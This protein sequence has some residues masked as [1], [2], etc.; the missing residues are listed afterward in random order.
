M[1]NNVNKNKDKKMNNYPNTMKKPIPIS[2]ITGRDSIFIKTKPNKLTYNYINNGNQIKNNKILIN[3]INQSSE[4]NKALKN[5]FSLHKSNYTK[6]I[7]GS[8]I[9]SKNLNNS[10]LNELI[11]IKKLSNN[12]I[13]KNIHYRGTNSFIKMNRRNNNSNINSYINNSSNHILSFYIFMNKKNNNSSVKGKN[14]F[15]HKLDKKELINRNINHKINNFN[16]TYIIKRKTSLINENRTN[17]KGKRV[18]T[19]IN[20]NSYPTKYNY[21]NNLS[22]ITNKDYKP[23][24]KIRYGKEN[25]Y[26]IREGKFNEP[27]RKYKLENKKSKNSKYIYS[28]EKKKEKSLE[29]KRHDAKKPI[30]YLAKN[31]LINNKDKNHQIKNNLIINIKDIN[32]T[33]NNNECKKEKDKNHKI[34]SYN[35]TKCDLSSTNYK[36]K[37]YKKNNHEKENNIKITKSNHKIFVAKK[38]DGNIK[39]SLNKKKISLNNK[40][41]LQR[42]N[43]I[44]N[45]MNSNNKIV[46]N[47][48]YY[49]INNTFIFDTAGHKLIQYDLSKL[50]PNSKNN[51]SMNINISDISNYNTCIPNNFCKTNST[52]IE[53]NDNKKIFKIN[54]NKIITKDNKINSTDN[55]NDYI[56]VVINNK[57][58][59]YNIQKYATYK[60]SNI[61]KNKINHNHLDIISNNDKFLI[62]NVIK[63]EST[64][65]NNINNKTQRFSNNINSNNNIS[66]DNNIKEYNYKKKKEFNRN[67]ILLNNKESSTNKNFKFYEQ[68]SITNFYNNHTSLYIKTLNRRKS[69]NI[70]N[71]EKKV[72]LNKYK[73]NNIINS[74]KFSSN[75][76]VQKD[77]TKLIKDN[78]NKGREKSNEKIRKANKDIKTKENKLISH[79]I[80]NFRKTKN[81]NIIFNINNSQKIKEPKLK[82]L[83]KEEKNKDNKKE[84]IK[85][86]KLTI[87]NGNANNIF[88]KNYGTFENNNENI[89][90][91]IDSIDL[92]NI[93]NKE[94]DK[95][96][97]NYT[98]FEL[99][100]LDENKIIEDNNK[101]VDIPDNNELFLDDNFDDINSI[102]KKIDFYGVR[103]NRDDIFSSNNIKYK[104]YS[105]KFDKL[106]D[107]IALKSN[108][109][110]SKNK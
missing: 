7:N 91:S 48:N 93:I 81:N 53:T 38:T 66:K 36:N 84:R 18:N 56:S 104:E 106:F 64:K 47:N 22:N 86:K 60:I 4:I 14:K 25:N 31:N 46:N 94:G 20:R 68:K 43:T 63:N 61:I 50:I 88:F 92:D 16:Y 101:F 77:D 1:L 26:T 105:K 96:D 8:T 28:I 102:I 27:S 35:R 80:M 89:N 108:K 54:D 109:K 107:D 103:N 65:Y 39:T 100:S 59:N 55:N 76:S 19:N 57:N 70:S 40:N 15:N 37:N 90:I 10:K 87:N 97:K 5:T 13:H 52:D 49:S 74:K 24:K 62:S 69:D 79:K 45:K 41:N 98:S 2:I 32:N 73:I 51:R 42:S 3:S 71:Y 11:K 34:T 58:N 99:I 29:E 75:N 85:E 23:F 95:S 82:K 44:E 21:S 12:N 9:E 33:Y 72:Q 6:S 67:K 17:S 110:S 30:S 83:K 78:K